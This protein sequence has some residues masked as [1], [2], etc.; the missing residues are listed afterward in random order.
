MSQPL[1]WKFLVFEGGGVSGFAAV[2][3][4][5]ELSSKGFDF[6]RVERC[7][8]TSIG[9]LIA[10]L[11]VVGALPSDCNLLKL[12]TLF[13]QF[14]RK[15]TVSVWGAMLRLL[16]NYGAVPPSALD[17]LVSA[18]FALRATRFSELRSNVTFAE[19]F[20]STGKVLVVTLHNVHTMENLY[21]HHVNYPHANVLSCVA[22]SMNVPGAFEPVRNLQLGGRE[23][24]GSWYVDGALLDNYPIA[25]FSNPTWEH[26][27]PTD[28]DWSV[29]IIDTLGFKMTEPNE[30]Y[31]RDAYE[32]RTVE[33]LGL[34]TY[35]KRFV[36]AA[37]NF[38]YEGLQW[39]KSAEENTLQLPAVG[40][41][42]V[43]VLRDDSQWEN[44]RNRVNQAVANFLGRRRL[45][46][47]LEFDEV[48]QNVAARSNP[49]NAHLGAGES[50][51]EQPDASGKA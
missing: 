25:L 8:G 39:S 21:V 28:V 35:A 13:V 3:A 43:S 22:A 2:M 11:V 1:G 45:S 29:E 24:V 26:V 27:L 17:E 7:A 31:A 19:L 41:L 47:E 20:R 46:I 14:A 18:C 44:L 5:A 6:D 32:P 15:Y 38:R 48:N 12:R 49:R 4:L 30:R 50:L 34:W 10:L 16:S 23:P 40:V 9:A 42:D 33:P 36:Y 37:L 51:P